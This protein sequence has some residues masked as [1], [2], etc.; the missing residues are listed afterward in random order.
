MPYWSIP[1]RIDDVIKII[2][3]LPRFILVDAENTTLETN[4]TRKGKET[5]RK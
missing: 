3:T 2:E 4:K 5:I 1:D